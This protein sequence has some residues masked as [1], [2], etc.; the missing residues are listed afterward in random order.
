MCSRTPG[1]HKMSFNSY[2]CLME[3]TSSKNVLLT[4]F[5]KGRSGRGRSGEYSQISLQPYFQ[6]CIARNPLLSFKPGKRIKKEKKWPKTSEKDLSWLSA[7]FCKPVRLSNT[8]KGNK[9]EWCEGCKEDLALP[10]DI[11]WQHKGQWTETET[12]GPSG[13]QETLTQVAQRGCAISTLWRYSKPKGTESWTTSS[14]WA[15]LSRLNQM[16][17]WGASQTQTICDSLKMEGKKPGK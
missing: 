15:C 8:H 10:S 2:S 12:G 11:Q 9:V 13:H 14:S 17:S 4:V 3:K 16:A 5:S 7:V 6:S 1:Y